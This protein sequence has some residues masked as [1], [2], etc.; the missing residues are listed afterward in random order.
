MSE[1]VGLVGLD[2]HW[3]HHHVH[4]GG[5]ELQADVRWT[6]VRDDTEG[7]LHYHAQPKRVKQT[8]LLYHPFVAFEIG[9]RLIF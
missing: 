3:D 8:M 5:V 6:K 2:K 1:L 7:S 4:H 9:I